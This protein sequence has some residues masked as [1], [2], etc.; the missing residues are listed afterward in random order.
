MIEG[1]FEGSDPIGDR[2]VGR[3]VQEERR[4]ARTSH[5]ARGTL[6]C[7]SC[8]APVAPARPLSPSDEIACP[9]CGGSG[10][11]RDFLSLA[12]PTRPAHVDVRIVAC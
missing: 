9:Y 1:R 10:P 11:V 2:P 7:P 4:R 8:D 6:A 5:L 12:E 3:M